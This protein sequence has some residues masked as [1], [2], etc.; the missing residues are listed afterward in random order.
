MTKAEHIAQQ[1]AKVSK[2][3]RDGIINVEATLEMDENHPN[4][5]ALE[6]DLAKMKEELSLI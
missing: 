1:D 4:K 5:I 2:I 6:A 3:L